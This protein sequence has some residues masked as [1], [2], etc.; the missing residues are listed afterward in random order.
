MDNHI[1]EIVSSWKN[2]IERIILAQPE[3]ITPL[4]QCLKVSAMIDNMVI[5]ILERPQQ[6]VENE[7]DTQPN[8]NGA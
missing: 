1:K 3:H 8:E 4:N 2:K 5:E 6:S 7:T